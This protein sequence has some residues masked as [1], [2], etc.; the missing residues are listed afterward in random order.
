VD[1]KGNVIERFLALVH[2]IDTTTDSLKEALFAV[3]DKHKLSISRIKEQGYYG[4]LNM[5]GEFNGLQ[6]SSR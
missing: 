2:V 5:R 1:A 4:A 6:K 3:L